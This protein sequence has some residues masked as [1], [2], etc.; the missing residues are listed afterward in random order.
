MSI[1][2]RTV[3]TKMPKK[4]FEVLTFGD[5]RVGQQFI[6]CPTP[7]DNRGHG[8]F[9]KAHYV[10]TKTHYRVMST[11]GEVDL[12]YDPAVPHGRAMKNCNQMISNFPLSMP[13]I[14]VE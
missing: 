11:G 13:V 6:G 14:L 3:R 10:F 12:P 7:G 2:V 9:K 8:G 5:L 4:C 1:T